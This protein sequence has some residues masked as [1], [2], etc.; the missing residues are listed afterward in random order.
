VRRHELALLPKLP[1]SAKS[2]ATLR[3]Q[4]YSTASAFGVA[5]ATMPSQEPHRSAQAM[6]R[7]L[8]ELGKL[9][10]YE[11]GAAARRD[12]AVFNVV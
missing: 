12:R 6:R 10:R 8:P 5:A 7:V 3:L 1:L 9:E 11:R 4:L 2:L